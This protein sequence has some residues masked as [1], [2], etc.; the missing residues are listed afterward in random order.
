MKQLLFIFIIPFLSFG[1]V[2]VESKINPILPINLD[3]DPSEGILYGG[4]LFYDLNTNRSISFDFVFGE[5]EF[6]ETINEQ[7]FGLEN[8]KKSDIRIA[9]LN[10]HFYPKGVHSDTENKIIFSYSSGLYI[11][12]TETNEQT[13]T[14]E[15]MITLD[16][17]TLSPVIA[18]GVV[19]RTDDLSVREIGFSIGVSVEFWPTNFIGLFGEAKL[20]FGFSLIQN[21]TRTQGSPNSFIEPEEIDISGTELVIGGPWLSC[22]IMVPLY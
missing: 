5:T 13:E 22:G 10:Y 17:T 21:G 9:S 4:G 8:F 12:T 11:K 7:E 16:A 6:S 18:D 3:D 14:V 1:Q 2:G 15:E 20:P 19:R